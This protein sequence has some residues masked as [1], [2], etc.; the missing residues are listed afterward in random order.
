MSGRSV[1]GLI[2]SGLVLLGSLAGCATSNAEVSPS[3]SSPLEVSGD[4]T[5]QAKQAL[6]K[7]GLE[8]PAGATN[9]TYERVQDE[10]NPYK[11]LYRI[12]FDLSSQKALKYCEEQGVGPG[13]S[14]DIVASQAKINFGFVPDESQ[15]KSR[16]DSLWDEDLRWNRAI[17]V[18]DENPATVW[19]AVGLMGR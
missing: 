10:Q 16:C 5:E 7:G 19:V 12:T 1:F 17:T 9:V 4:V 2:F 8:L 11:D 6:A 15:L 18:N 14:G 3:P 13:F